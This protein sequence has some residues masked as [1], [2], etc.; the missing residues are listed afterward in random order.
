MVMVDCGYYGNN[1]VDKI[2]SVTVEFRISCYTYSTFICS[3]NVDICKYSVSVLVNHNITVYCS[4]HG[5]HNFNVND[6]TTTRFG[7]SHFFMHINFT[8]KICFR[9]ANI[10]IACYQ[11]LLK[12]TINCHNHGNLH[13]DDFVNTTFQFATVIT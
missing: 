2:L 9:N 11:W 6:I 13:L 10:L 7:I 3:Q 5:N 4:Y 12:V 8:N 1:Y